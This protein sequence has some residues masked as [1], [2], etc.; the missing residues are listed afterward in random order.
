MHTQYAYIIIA[1]K[2]AIQRDA[3]VCTAYLLSNK[4]TTNNSTKYCIVLKHVQSFCIDYFV[5]ATM[6]VNAV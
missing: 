5:T 6:R 2:L 1:H 4:Y 3:K